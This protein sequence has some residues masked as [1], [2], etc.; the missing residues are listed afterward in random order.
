MRL[1]DRLFLLPQPPVGSA[2]AAVFRSAR[3]HMVLKFL[4]TVLSLGVIPLLSPE[5]FDS[6]VDFA[7]GSVDGPEEPGSGIGHYMEFG[8]LI[9]AGFTFM[10]AMTVALADRYYRWYV[11]SDRSLTVRQ[12][13]VNPRQQTLSFANV[14]NVEISQGPLQRVFGIS[15][16]SVSVA[17]G[18]AAKGAR[19]HG[20][21][22]V[23]V[24]EAE[25]IKKAIL[26]R[27]RRLREAEAHLPPSEEAESDADQ[28]RSAFDRLE[29]ALGITSAGD[30]EVA[31]AG[32]PSKG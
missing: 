20:A 27:Q 21:E 12:G 1:I 7:F 31:T 24:K 3:A 28:L 14:Q 4:K 13:V 2:S 15:T 23:G 10:I 19:A 9:F 17:G 26:D 6:V 25:T 29:Q 11:L 22:F 5:F 32:V 8:Y 16:V 18:G 30:I